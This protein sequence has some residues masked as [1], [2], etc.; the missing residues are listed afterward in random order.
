MANTLIF[1][2][3]W[4]AV[5]Y[6]L[7]NKWYPLNT[8]TKVAFLSGTSPLQYFLPQM[9]ISQ[10]PRHREILLSMRV[11]IVWKSLLPLETRVRPIFV[12]LKKKEGKPPEF[13]SL[14]ALLRTAA[15]EQA[16]YC[17][18]QKEIRFWCGSRCL[19]EG[20]CHSVPR[21]CYERATGALKQSLPIWY[22][23]C[24]MKLSVFCWM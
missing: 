13:F 11:R 6:Q 9:F 15:W 21:I 22:M 3:H 8:N 5:I 1:H 20:L 16:K 4:V 24:T 19:S 17:M 7:Q 23:L 14:A 10:V 12:S 2:D 18:I